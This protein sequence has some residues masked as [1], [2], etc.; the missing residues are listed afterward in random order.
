MI[1]SENLKKI[2]KL[3]SLRTPCLSG[4]EGN[5]EGQTSALTRR[6]FVRWL[7]G[8]PFLAFLA[9][10]ARAAMTPASIPPRNE[11]G[12]SIA[13]FF[14]GEELFYEIGVWPFKQVALGKLN[15]KAME[16]KGRY[17]ATLRGETLGVLGWIARY[18]TDTYRATMEEIEGG[19]RLR[20][21]SFEEDVK[22]GNKLKRSVHL[23]DYQK[24]KWVK[25]RRRKD[26]S[27]VRTVEE[28]P[29]DR[30]YDDFITASYNFRYGV[31][32]EVERG[33]K[34]T[35]ATFPKKGSPHYE[36]SIASK[37]EEEKKKKSETFKEGKDFFVKLFLDPEITHSKEGLIEGW[38]S[39]E[40]YPMEG[41]IK[42]VTLIGDVKGT[43]IKKVRR[44][45]SSELGLT[46][47]EQMIKNV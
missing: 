44:V 13:Q 21:L 15:F 2:L 46:V 12:S 30:V 40:F 17:T 28:I 43:L 18:R 16:E 4:R 24:R 42:G 1:R 19:K 26:G 32:G 47:N 41:T 38:L 7:L 34:Y 9:F 29:R 8:Q 27:I 5:S 33:K 31:Y 39:R 35:I 36:L 14:N 22:V 6:L 10:N 11:R 45:K 3:L 20:S 23:F 25:I 37:E